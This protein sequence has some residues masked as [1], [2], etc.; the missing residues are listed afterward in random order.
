MFAGSCEARGWKTRCPAGP[1]TRLDPERCISP[2]PPVFV[3]QAV[4]RKL[5]VHWPTTWTTRSRAELND[6]WRVTLNLSVVTVNMFE[7][8]SSVSS[9]MESDSGEDAVQRAQN[10]QQQPHT[11]TGSIKGNKP[12][13]YSTADRGRCQTLTSTSSSISRLALLCSRALGA[14]SFS[15][16]SVILK[17]FHSRI[18]LRK[19]RPPKPY[20]AK[21]A[22]F[23]K[24]NLTG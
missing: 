5:T 19:D 18:S 20:T 13:L 11:S 24:H 23:S 10:N 12:S 2:S 14:L 3:L 8:W 9:K 7:M 15:L 16:L 21:I 22:N 17:R 4:V 1:H 6:R